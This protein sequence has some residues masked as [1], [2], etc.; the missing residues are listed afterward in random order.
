MAFQYAQKF[1]EQPGSLS[2]PVW[3]KLKWLLSG[4]LV[5]ALAI[6]LVFKKF[7]LDSSKSVSEKLESLDDIKVLKNIKSLFPKKISSIE[8][9]DDGEYQLVLS[10]GTETDSVL[11]LIVEIKAGATK[12]KIITFS[13]QTFLVPK[14]D[15]SS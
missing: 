9:T 11:P 15:G 1:K 14:A 6:A 5:T 12:K 7:N 2:T 4:G 8:S 10:Q 13:G 3:K